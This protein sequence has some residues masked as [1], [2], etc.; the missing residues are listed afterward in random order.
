MSTVLPTLVERLREAV[1]TF[2][3]ARQ[4]QGERQGGDDEDARDR[5]GRSAVTGGKHMDGFIRLVRAI[6]AEAGL[7]N[8]RVFCKPLEDP[9]APQPRRPRRRRRGEGEDDTYEA[10]AT[11]TILPGWFRAEKDWDLIVLVG[12]LLVAVVEFKSH[13]GSFGNNCN[14]RI[15]EALGNSTD[16]LAAYREGAFRP[17]LRPW[18]GYLMLLEEAPGS[19]RPVRVRQPHFRVFPE[20]Q[21]ASYAERYNQLLTKLVRERLYDSC[22]FLMSNATGGPATGEYREPNVELGFANFVASLL[23]HATSVARTQ[24]PEAATSTEQP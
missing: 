7:A 11:D 6:V 4:E 23:A 24:P 16:L 18:L 13:V 1:R 12:R 5:G 19:T 14:N 8:A 2:W 10:I 21:G 20:F 9:T 22:C 17:A 3:N 15:E